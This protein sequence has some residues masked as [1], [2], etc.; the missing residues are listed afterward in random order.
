MFDDLRFA[1]RRLRHSPGFTGVALLTLTLAIGVN[2]SVLSVADAVLFRPLPYDDP[3]RV[4]VLQMM[5]RQSGQRYTRISGDVLQAI[6]DRHAGV[7]KI[8]L[9]QSRP[10]IVV[11]GPDGA[12]LVRVAG[13][14]DN[15]F[16]LLGVRAAVGRVLD[17]RDAAATG[18][19]I[20]LTHSA[21]LGRFGGD[22]RIVGQP[23]SL[24]GATYD[25]VGV[26]PADFVFPSTFAGRPE[27]VALLP[28]AAFKAGAFHPVVRL[29]PGRSRAEAQAEMDSLVGPVTR[30][31]EGGKEISVA[32]DPVRSVIYPTA[33]SIMLFLVAAASLVLLIGCANLASMLLARNTRLERENGVRAAL[34]AR[35]ARLVRPVLFES[36]A[37]G[38]VGSAL[39][40]LAAWATFDLLLPHVP[41]VAYGAAPVGPDARVAVIAFAMGIVA[42]LVFAAV[43]AWQA[44]RIDPQVL[45]QARQRAPRA[46]G[47]MRHPL[48][49]L[50]VA[51]SVVLIFGAVVAARA[52]MARLNVPLGFEPAGVVKI[53]VR[54]NLQ[55]ER[56]QAY[57]VN[58]LEAIS[59][60][61][62][63]SAAGAAG[64]IPL[65]S[66]APDEAMALPD[67]SPAPAGLVHTLPGYFEAAGIPLVRGRSLA[68]DDVRSDTGAAVLSQSAAA[69]VFPGRDALGQA[70]TNGRGRRFTVVGVVGDVLKS[71]ETAPGRRDPPPVYIIPGAAVRQLT[72][73]ARMR[74]GVTGDAVL[75]DLKRQIALVPPLAPAG[76]EWWSKW[77]GLLADYKNPRFQTIVLGGFGL[78]ALVLTATG[79]FAMISFLVASRTREIGIRIAIG[80]ASGAVVNYMARR[81]L[82]PVL[83]GTIAGVL[84]TRWIA[85]FA[86]AQLFKVDADDPLTL[87]IASITVLAAAMVAAYVPARHA[88]RVDPI[89]ALRAD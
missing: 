85:K 38:I 45:L 16:V 18:R 48:I 20:L 78:L 35:P 59:S 12:D 51:A 40:L 67:G 50:Q 89:V 8:A 42:G 13:V 43:P 79:V 62:D 30:P 5:D 58:L 44:A 80:A 41:R 88:A 77:I 47:W 19:P 69:V 54:P 33:R 55:G 14:T 23:L 7:S 4:F 24:G 17:Q 2:V 72:V 61:A 81:A 68:M 21:W 9:V 73:I 31:T 22:R 75:A 71:H 74:P 70:F 52:F 6:D 25:V 1:L 63:V 65:D 37:I 64:S 60:R 56:L 49:G 29:E 86:E 87:V 10:S 57:Y 39:A 83:L 84:A 34:G 15:Y 46:R 26:L 28:P 11:Q 82:A 36:M 32:L 53:N 66:F 76:T 27:V 3:D